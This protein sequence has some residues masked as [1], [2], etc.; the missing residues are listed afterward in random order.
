MRNFV[1]HK[2]FGVELDDIWSTIINDIPLLKQQIQ[3][4][5]E[6]LKNDVL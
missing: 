2:Y 5:I 3:Q 1:T 6:D 4:I